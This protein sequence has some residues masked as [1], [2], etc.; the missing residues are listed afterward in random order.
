[1]SDKL[2]DVISDRNRFRKAIL[3]S[4]F[5]SGA[6]MNP[7]QQKE[8]AQLVRGSRVF[9]DQ[10]A[11]FEQVENLDGEMPRM[12]WGEPITAKAEETETTA[13]T[14][15]PKLDAIS[16][17]GQTVKVRIE[18]SYKSLLHAAGG[19]STF[20]AAVLA[21]IEN[22]HGV[23]VELVC[24]EGD[25]TTYAA[26]T[27]K[28][29]ML[30]KTF[31]GWYLQAQ[32]ARVLDA[33]GAEIDADLLF[34][35]LDMYPDSA[36]TDKTKWL[37]NMGLRRDYRR[38]LATKTGGNI[39]E[40]ALTGP[41]YQDMIFPD[42]PALPIS[43]IPKSKEVSIMAATPAQ[44]KSVNTGPFTI[45]AGSTTGLKV[46]IDDGAYGN[47]TKTLALTAGKARTTSQIA[48]ALNTAFGRVVAR[49]WD[50]HL[51][52]Y[53]ENTGVATEVEVMA[54]ALDCYTILGLTASTATGSDAG[55]AGTRYEGTYMMLT[56]PSNLVAIKGLHTRMHVGWEKNTDHLEI[57]IFDEYDATIEDLDAMV[58]IKNIKKMRSV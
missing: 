18:L 30:L 7:D 50:G 28:Y 40:Q 24:F 27:D 10:F 5:A 36:V 1:M 44:V 57:V 21:G 31:D 56:D 3:E 14:G 29:S 52:I 15:Q 54:V 51:L 58:L 32:Q 20:E 26:G 16:Y 2:L 39:L 6:L 19:K 49:D 35:A 33:G 25:T 43:A 38:Y 13:Q 23:D 12:H 4:D 46:R 8:W 55:T 9:L 11:R 42:A 22:R 47:V 48:E 37:C 53:C 34:E 41:G 45:T 17:S